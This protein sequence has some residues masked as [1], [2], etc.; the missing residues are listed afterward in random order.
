[1]VR[2]KIDTKS[3][4]LSISHNDL[5]GVVC[6]IILGQVYKNIHYI[7]ASFYKIDS[8]LKEIHFDEY[9][10][11]FLTDI[12]PDEQE[13]LYLSDKIIMID[14]HKSAKNMHNP[15]KFHYVLT[16]YCAS[17]YVKNFIKS[18]YKIK[19]THLDQLV[20]LTNDYDMYYLKNPKSKLLYDLMFNFYKPHKFRN[21]FFN[22]RT[23]FNINEIE[24]L[25]KRRKEYEKRWNNLD[26]YEL[27]SIKGCIIEQ[28]DFMNEIADRLINEECYRVV[29][30][31]NPF[32]QRVSIRHN[33]D[34]F[35]AGKFLKDRGWGGGHE[36]AAGMFL[37]GEEDFLSKINIIEKYIA[38]N[39]DLVR[40]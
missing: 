24:W 11:V 38:N 18:L 22:G 14:H 9:D 7:N 1:M 6:Q 20:Y 19:L 40:I 21:E 32:T 23:K 12:H 10:Y 35:D 8:I 34:N 4:I 27:N 30:I 31:R 13:N 3:K 37:D 33:I 2:P 28:S 26:V 17:V 39:F 36:R 29:L 15:S 5:D 25:K 16:D